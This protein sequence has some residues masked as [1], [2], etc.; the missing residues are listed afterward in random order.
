MGLRRFSCGSEPRSAWSTALLLDDGFLEARLNE[1]GQILV[2]A[3]G[4]DKG[5]GYFADVLD[6][7]GV[8]IVEAGPPFLRRGEAEIVEGGFVVG[9]ADLDC[10]VAGVVDFEADAAAVDLEDAGFVGAEVELAEPNVL[11]RAAADGEHEQRERGEG[12]E[13]HVAS[14]NLSRFGQLS[15][16]AAW[17]R[18]RGE[19][20][21][22]GA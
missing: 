11:A 2:A 7:D 16:D 8:V 13:A 4:I 9:D 21:R 14:L 5:C 20:V 1:D 22:C 10:G 12:D 19:R 18:G 6:A 3:D 15:G 17:V